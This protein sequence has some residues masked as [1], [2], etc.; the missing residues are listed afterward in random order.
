M[1]FIRGRNLTIRDAVS[2]A[3]VCWRAHV[4]LKLIAGILRFWHEESARR[5]FFIGGNLDKKGLGQSVFR[6]ETMK[7][8]TIRSSNRNHLLSAAAENSTWEFII[9]CASERCSQ[10]WSIVWPQ[11][12]SQKSFVVRS[13]YSWH[14]ECPHVLEIRF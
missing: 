8:R 6:F 9:S 14:I 10:Q 7:R 11:L 12:S 4:H 13:P 3:L 1:L 5:D 2:Y